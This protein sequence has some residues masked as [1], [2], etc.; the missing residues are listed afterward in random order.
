MNYATNFVDKFRQYHKHLSVKI[1]NALLFKYKSLHSIKAQND[2]Q[3]RIVAPSGM[4]Q[5]NAVSTWVILL[6]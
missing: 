4:E 2:T 6:M 1:G 3:A 5:V